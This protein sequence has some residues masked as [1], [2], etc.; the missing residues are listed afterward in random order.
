MQNKSLLFL[1]LFLLMAFGNVHAEGKNIN[2][3]MKHQGFKRTFIIHLPEGYDANKKYPM[4]LAIHGG[5]GT[6]WKGMERQAGHG[7]VRPGLAR[8]GK[9]GRAWLGMAWQGAAG[10]GF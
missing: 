5:L 7:K 10:R 1:P 4:L 8:S 9:A 6:A 3:T 2:K